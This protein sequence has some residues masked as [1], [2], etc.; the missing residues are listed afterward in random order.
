[1]GDLF[2]DIRG[3]HIVIIHGNNF[4]SKQLIH[5][6]ILET[7]GKTFI[8]ISLMMGVTIVLYVLRRGDIMRRNH[9][10]SAYVDVIVNSSH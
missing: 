8:H 6:N 9:P 2:C 1:M 10:V 5:L 7:I 3:G 4:N